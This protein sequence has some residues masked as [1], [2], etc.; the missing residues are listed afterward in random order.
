MTTTSEDSILRFRYTFKIHDSD[1][2]VDYQFALNSKTLLFIP[3]ETGPAKL[4]SWADLTFCQCSNCPLDSKKISQCPI[5]SN[6]NN[7]VYSFNDF[8]SYQKATIIVSTPER[9]YFTEDSVQIGLFS[10]FGVIMATSG[11]P[12]MNFL[13]PM[14]RFHLPFATVE[15][16][17]FRSTSTFLLREYLIKK[18]QNSKHEISL[19]NMADL[20]KSVELVNDGI[21]KRI[22]SIAIADADQNALVIL[23]SFAQIIGMESENDYSELT[24]IFFP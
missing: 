5:A 1:R 18:T 13:R 17:I 3:Q 4:S 15:E 24:K 6:I 10:I 11:C 8:R 9:K 14:A 12:H 22:H 21:L 20:Y 19:D 7:L 16:T 23:N 2:V